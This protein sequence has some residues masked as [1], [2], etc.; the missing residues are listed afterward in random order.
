MLQRKQCLHT[1]RHGHDFVGCR[2]YLAVIQAYKAEVV[3][4]MS[5][6]PLALTQILGG[7]AQGLEAVCARGW[8]LY[9]HI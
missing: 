5:S 9:M 3:L 6:V 1:P 4:L 7:Y 8:P 2:A